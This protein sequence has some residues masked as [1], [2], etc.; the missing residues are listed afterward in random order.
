MWLNK[1]RSSIELLQ[2]TCTCFTN[3]ILCH[4]SGTECALYYSLPKG[5]LRSL[6]V[7]K[8]KEV[9]QVKRKFFKLWNK[10]KSISQSVTKNSWKFISLK[11][12]TV[13]LQCVCLL[14]KKFCFSCLY[15]LL[16]LYIL[17]LSSNIFKQSDICCRPFRIH[18]P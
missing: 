5:N 10:R 3:L 17:A 12:W 6:Q 18:S 4:I 11:E 2:K 15:R 13:F 14:H 9:L 16:E 8:Q 7:M 1:G